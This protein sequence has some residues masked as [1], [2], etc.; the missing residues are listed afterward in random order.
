[1]KFR[2]KSESEEPMLLDVEVETVDDL[3]DLEEESAG[4]APAGA[5]AREAAGPFDTDEAYSEEPRIDLGSLLLPQREGVDLQLQIE[6]ETGQVVAVLLTAEEGGV[7]LRAFA[8]PRAGDLWAEALPQLAA[9]AAQRGG[10]TAHR[11]GRWGPELLCQ[12]PVTMPDGEEGVQ[13]SRVVGVNGPRWLLR[14]TFLGAPAVDQSIGDQW[15]DL[16][17]SIV[18]HR[19][20]GP[21]PVG[22]ALPL[23]IPPTGDA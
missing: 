11:E 20:E 1:V 7:E 19:G 17:A 8:A 2:R 12:F 10:A 6:Q 4:D 13:P 5:T 16:L 21:L 15:D 3:D 22:E 14:A 9:D 23:V 18:V